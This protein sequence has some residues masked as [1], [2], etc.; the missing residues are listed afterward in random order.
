MKKILCLGL[1]VGS[2]IGLTGCEVN[3]E[4]L[5]DFTSF[6]YSQNVTVPKGILVEEGKLIVGTSPDYAP[7]SF[8]DAELTG[9]SK[10]QGS[11]S[12]IAM[13]VAQSLGLELEFKEVAFDGLT[14]SLDNKSIDVI[15]SGLT[16]KASR[17]EFYTFTET[18]YNSGDGGQ[19][20]VMQKSDVNSYT[21]LED[22]NSSNVK[23]AAQNA[24]LQYELVESQLD[25]VNIQTI[26][27]IA[28]GVTLLK[29]GNVQFLASSYTSALAIVAANEDLVIV[30]SDIFE[31]S[32]LEYGTMGLLIKD[33]PLVEYIN[34][35]IIAFDNNTYGQWLVE[36]QE[37]A[38]FISF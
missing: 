29:N 24:S 6:D 34:K 5:I 7:Y 17:E 1:L 16:Y 2:I 8:L 11:E 4:G 38:D 21:S 19:V 31:F 27:A 9:L 15:F 37:Y 18:Y 10:F 14:A 22:I 36:Y 23:V 13:Y 25:S 3:R 12:A 30:S 26:A 28:D 33:S 20:L 32:V 35:A